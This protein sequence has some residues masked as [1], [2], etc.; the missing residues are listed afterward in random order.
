MEVACDD[1]AFDFSDTDLSFVTPSKLKFMQVKAW[2]AGGNAEANCGGTMDSG[3]GGY[4]EAYFE[5]EPGTPMVVIIGEY[6]NA[7][8]GEPKY[9]FG[10]GG[11]GG[12]SGVFVGADEVLETDQDRA[13]IIAGGGGSA[14]RDACGLGIPGNHPEAGGMP[15]MQGGLATTGGGGGYFGGPAGGSQ[16]P[17]IGGTGYI[18][19]TAEM[20]IM[21]YAEPGA[22]VP[23]NDADPEYDG[24]AG[25]AESNGQVVIHFFC[26][27]PIPG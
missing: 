19:P 9:G 26:E 4:S 13:L 3:M 10:G 16:V 20:P 23:P 21:L 18:D 22:G 2:G 24:A 27:D 14:A 6:G 1:I 8:M 5:V 17:G 15:T 11:G 25:K 12:L 7:N